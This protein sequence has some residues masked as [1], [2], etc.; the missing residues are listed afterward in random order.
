MREYPPSEDTYLLIDHMKCG[1]RVLE[2]GTGSGEVAIECAKRGSEVTAVDIDS[3][4]IE[5][6]KER[7]AREGLN[8]SCIQSDLFENVHGKYDTIIFNPPYL[9]G[10]PESIVD[11]QWAGGGKYG[12]EIILRFLSEAHKYLEDYGEIYLILSSFNRL[13]RIF[14]YP[15]EFRKIADLKLSFHSI[16]LYLLKKRKVYI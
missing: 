13:N 15:Y 10:E 14:A 1:K 2:I 8:I 4:A 9:P 7:C 16:Y 12:D 6:L 3:A 5:K 11:Y